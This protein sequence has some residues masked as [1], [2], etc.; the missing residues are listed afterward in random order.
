MGKGRTGSSMGGLESSPQ[1][2]KRDRKKRKRE[3][4]RWA[5][6]SGPVV[7]KRIEDESAPQ[8]GGRDGLRRANAED[9]R[10][11]SQVDCLPLPERV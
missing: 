9:Q 7:V 2:K 5:A 8:E 11:D 4:E 6:K 1:R 10:S 3:E